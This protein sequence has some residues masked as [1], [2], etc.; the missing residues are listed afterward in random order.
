VNH[1][2][3]EQGVAYRLQDSHPVHLDAEARQDDRLRA[4]RAAG[5]EPPKDGARWQGVGKVA[6][7][8]KLSRQTL[9]DDLKAALAR[10]RE[11]RRAGAAL[12]L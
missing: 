4:Y 11:K 10:E 12:K 1:W 6:A 8:L 7:S 2:L 3:A 9:T 5:Y